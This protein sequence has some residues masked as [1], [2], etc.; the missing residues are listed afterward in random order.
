MTGTQWLYA[1]IGVAAATYCLRA[2]PLLWRRL[3]VI[4][5]RN[6]AFL[7]YVSFAIAAG[8]VSKAVVVD[9]GHWAAPADVIVKGLAVL[10]GVALFRIVRQLPLAL[11]GGVGLAVLLK[12]WGW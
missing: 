4:G 11:F 3:R 10:T 12:W 7:S 1:I 8:I 2:A 5:A 6:I 9:G